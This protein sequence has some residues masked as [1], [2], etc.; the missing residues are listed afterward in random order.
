MRAILLCRGDRVP[1]KKLKGDLPIE[2]RQLEK[3]VGKAWQAHML[4]LM[5]TP[6]GRS[7]GAI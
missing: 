5:R 6:P 7:N 4:Q 1:K 3:G 2:A